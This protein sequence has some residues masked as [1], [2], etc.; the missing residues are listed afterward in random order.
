MESFSNIEKMPCALLSNVDLPSAEVDGEVV[1]TEI[2]VEYD[3][4]TEQMVWTFSGKSFIYRIDRAREFL[5]L[6]KV[7]EETFEEVQELEE[8]E[9]FK[10]CDVMIE[11]EGKVYSA[12]LTLSKTPDYY[13]VM[14][15]AQDTAIDDDLKRKHINHIILWEM[16]DFQDFFQ[17]VTTT[18]V[19]A[20]NVKELQ[21]FDRLYEAE[22]G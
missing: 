9:P 18:Q 21:A 15:L 4:D 10:L 1:N 16:S 14:T 19:T 22:M 17:W 8:C 20:Y 7:M 11:Y 2:T 12:V 6:Q 13:D 3:N 5:F